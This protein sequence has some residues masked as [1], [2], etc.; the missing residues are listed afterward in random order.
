[1]FLLRSS[2]CRGE[3]LSKPARVQHGEFSH[4]PNFSGINH[5]IVGIRL[6]FDEMSQNQIKNLNGLNFENQ[7]VTIASKIEIRLLE[8]SPCFGEL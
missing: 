4:D 2:P 7:H 3:L 1:M 6:L 8:V 5:P